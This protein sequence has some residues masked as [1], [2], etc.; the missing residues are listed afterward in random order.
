M[1]ACI[2]EENR[3]TGSL[4]AVSFGEDK[5]K[6]LTELSAKFQ[7]GAPRDE[8]IAQ[9]Q[10][11]LIQLAALKA[12]YAK[13]QNAEKTQ[14]EKDLEK[15]FMD[16]LPSEEELSEKGLWIEEY[17]QKETQLKELYAS[18]V[19]TMSVQPTQT[20]K[21]KNMT[22]L[23]LSF[24]CF[25]VGIML[26]ALQLIPAGIAAL[27]VGVVGLIASV[28]M[29]SKKQTSAPVQTSE[30][31]LQIAKLQSDLKMLEEKIRAYTVGYGYYSTAGVAYD[32]ATLEEDARAYRVQLVLAQENAQKA[33]TLFAEME[34]I[35]PVLLIYKTLTPM[36]WG[37]LMRPGTRNV[38]IFISKLL[39][40]R[41]TLV[42]CAFQGH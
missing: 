36:G 7:N 23:G 15:R 13:L 22:G 4:Q 3:L 17:K 33:R 35:N 21:G 19:S 11:N 41:H 16:K 29:L 9:K 24:V 10:Q 31:A 38:E 27:A 34:Q 5:E 25:A 12:E 39:A 2:Q 32:F 26:F 20:G 28:A 37:E 42:S 1:R 30:I 40:H 8:D 18:P 14:R 6:I